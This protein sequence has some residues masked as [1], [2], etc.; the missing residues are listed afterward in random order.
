MIPDK[1]ES[2][3]R[4][5]R[6]GLL[7]PEIQKEVLELASE[8]G[9]ESAVTAQSD[10][11]FLFRIYQSGRARGDAGHKALERAEDMIMRLSGLHHAI[12]QKE[13][14]RRTTER[15]RR[16]PLTL[17][18]GGLAVSDKTRKLLA[19]IGIEDESTITR[20]V[21]MFGE[22][23]TAERAGLVL[24]MDVGIETLR[25]IFR[26]HPETIL[27]PKDDDFVSELD[28][29]EK[30]RDVIDGWAFSNG[31]DAPAWADYRKTPGILLD[32][33]QDIIRQLEIEL[34]PERP[35]REEKAV[36]FISKPM[37]PDDFIKVVRGLG[38]EKMRDASHGTL[39][40][41]GAGNIMCVAKS[42]RSQSE[43]NGSTIK[44]KLVEA[45]VDIGQFERK[46]REMGL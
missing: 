36:K 17:V 20:A 31:K 16:I 7:E 24:A 38:F 35:A 46:R 2:A 13:A 22:E 26:A 29:I 10:L 25:G 11:H 43:L 9:W 14:A 15:K 19:S 33:F 41:D 5:M 32:T 8:L 37:H 30:K 45:G 40:R 27:F 23:K 21:G 6:F 39:M 28:A 3:L 44:K 4:R 18:E 42:H 1:E 34:P 12:A